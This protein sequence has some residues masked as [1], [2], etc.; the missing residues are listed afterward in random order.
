MNGFWNTVNLT[1]AGIGYY[2]AAT[3][4]PSGLMLSETIQAQH[5]MEKILL[6]N[7]GL[8]LAYMAGGLYLQQ[9]AK[10]TNQNRLK[11]F[12]QSLVLQGA[13]LFVFDI[14]FYLVQNN[15]GKQLLKFVDELAISPMGVQFTFYL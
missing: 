10:N 3:T 11:G 5:S 12:G 9:R 1:L 7:A 8:D 6:F 14:G 13:F 15:H 4:D 2:S